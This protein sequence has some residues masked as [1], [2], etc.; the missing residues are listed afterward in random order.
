[1]EEEI[2]SID[3]AHGWPQNNMTLILNT[4]RVTEEVHSVF[5]NTVPS[6]SSGV[7][8]YV[9]FLPG[10]LGSMLSLTWYFCS[11]MQTYG[12]VFGLIQVPKV[13]VRQFSFPSSS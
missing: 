3:K 9:R 11:R 12:H 8:D 6:L 4:C 5:C 1:M 7:F 13:R 2:L 10:F